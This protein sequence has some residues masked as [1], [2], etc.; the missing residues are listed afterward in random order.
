MVLDSRVGALDRTLGFPCSG[1]RVGDIGRGFCSL[2]GWC[3]TAASRN[4]PQRQVAGR[5]A[6]HRRLAD[7]DADDP[8]STI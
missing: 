4:G 6:R 8:K 7:V 1:L 5:A 3:P 2:P